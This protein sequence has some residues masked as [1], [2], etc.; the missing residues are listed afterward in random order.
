MSDTRMG[1]PIPK[2]PW[3]WALYCESIKIIGFSVFLQAFRKTFDVPGRTSSAAGTLLRQ[4]YMTV[5]QYAVQFCTLT[6]ELAW[7]N[8]ALTATFWQGLADCI[9]DQL[10]GRTISSTLDYLIALSIQID[11]HIQ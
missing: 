3:A 4:G 7:N 8:E 2:I 6:S 5:D 10:A 1:A 9:K 11:V